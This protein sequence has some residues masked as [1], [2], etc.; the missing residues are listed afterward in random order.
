MEREL[1]ERRGAELEAAL[2]LVTVEPPE[3][4]VA[5]LGE[6]PE[7]PAAR[8]TWDRAALELE[9]FR[10][11]HLDDPANEPT[12]L[13]P[14]PTSAADRAAW[15]NTARA[16]ERAREDLG[17]EPAGGELRAGLAGVPELGSRPGLD[18]SP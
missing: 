13:G 15:R 6:R 17:L 18:F 14:T 11:D 8:A 4:T 5:A 7:G 3:H 16:L 9:R 2:R 12:P 1:G 10:W